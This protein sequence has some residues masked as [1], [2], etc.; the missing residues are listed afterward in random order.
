MANYVTKQENGHLTLSPG[1]LINTMSPSSIQISTVNLSN[2]GCTF[3][4]FTDVLEKKEGVSDRQELDGKTYQ[5]L[6]DTAGNLFIKDTRG[7]IASVVGFSAREIPIVL[8]KLQELT[9]A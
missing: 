9:K 5:A 8:T 6:T 4:W 3:R 1:D 7:N 2:E